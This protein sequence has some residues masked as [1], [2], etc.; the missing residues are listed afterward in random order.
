MA[1]SVP[2]ARL[3]APAHPLRRGPVGYVAM[4]TGAEV[5]RQNVRQILGTARGERVMRPDFGCD[6]GRLVFAPLDKATES[7]ARHLVAEALGTWEPRVDVLDVTTTRLP[8]EQKLRVAV[9]YSIRS[10]GERDSAV[11]EVFERT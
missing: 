5:I 6:L 8:R 1:G 7:L 11:V 9:R 3:R 10:T 2:I 4:A